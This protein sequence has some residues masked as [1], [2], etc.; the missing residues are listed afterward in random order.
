MYSST[1]GA[2]QALCRPLLYSI[3]PTDGLHSL[4][5]LRPPVVVFDLEGHPNVV[6]EQGMLFS[7]F[8]EDQ[9]AITRAQVISATHEEYLASSRTNTLPLTILNRH[10]YKYK[11]TN[12]CTHTH[13]H[14]THTNMQT[15]VHTHILTHTERDCYSHLVDV[16]HV[17]DKVEY[18]HKSCGVLWGGEPLELWP[19][20]VAQHMA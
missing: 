10:R 4:H 6:E 20:E 5:Y 1:R 7:V 12:T 18:R 2:M 9:L 3:P 17:L 13:T 15:H 14:T 11:H 16:G 19:V 8:K